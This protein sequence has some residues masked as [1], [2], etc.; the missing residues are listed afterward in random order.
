MVKSEVNRR[1][2][3][4]SSLAFEIERASD[5]DGLVRKNRQLLVYM[6][7]VRNALQHPRHRSAGGAIEVSRSFLRETKEVLQHLENPPKASDVGVPRKAIL[8]AK[9]DDSLG[10]LAD[11]MKRN[12][13]SHIP[14]VDERDAVIGVFNEAAVFDH[15]WANDETIIGRDMRV[16]D[17]FTHC[18]LDAVHTETFA[19]VRPRTLLEDLVSMFL[20]LE[21]ATSRVGAAFVTASGKNFEPLQR[22]IT[23][24]DVLAGSAA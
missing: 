5:R 22:L 1:A 16:A 6:R 10:D 2:G 11:Q 13:F 4:P 3:T 15:L 21:S 12:G 8:T 14:I 17:I 18:R 24:W 9:V 23:P 7:D 19:F 20:A